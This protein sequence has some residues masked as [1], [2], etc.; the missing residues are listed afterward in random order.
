M[1]RG[2]VSSVSIGSPCLR[3]LFWI[4]KPHRQYFGSERILC[5]RSAVTHPAPHRS[6]EFPA[7][8]KKP[9][10]KRGAS[11]E[12]SRRRPTLPGSYPPSTIGAG[13]LNFRVR[14]GN[15]CDLRRYGHRKSVRPRGRGTVAVSAST[16]RPGVTEDHP[17]RSIA[18]TSKFPSP[19]PI[20]TG[21]LNALPHLH[22]RPINVVVWPRALPG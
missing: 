4:L 20:S 2:V 6:P 19:R 5:I 14:N 16:S 22:L 9:P 8:A 7:D 10:A 12:K 15:G 1:G 13:G 21:R 3:D 18:S 17:E 11:P